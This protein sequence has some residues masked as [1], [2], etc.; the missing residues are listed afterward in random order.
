MRNRINLIGRLG[1]DPEVI[2][3]KDGKNMT[4]IRLAT[5]EYY[6]NDRGERIENTEWHNCIAF[7]KKAETLSQYLVKGNQLAIMGKVTY[8]KYKDDQGKT[9]SNT[10]ILINEFTFI[11]GKPKDQRAA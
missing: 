1:M 5:S 4:K 11:D 8:R 6:V 3:T 7:G 2:E 10:S 9:R